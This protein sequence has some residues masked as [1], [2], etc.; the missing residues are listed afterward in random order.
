MRARL[1]YKA[2][3]EANDREAKDTFRFQFLKYCD[4]RRVTATLQH[5]GRADAAA[6]NRDPRELLQVPKVFTEVRNDGTLRDDVDKLSTLKIRDAVHACAEHAGDVQ[7]GAVLLHVLERVLR[8]Q[9]ADVHAI[10]RLHR[11]KLAQGPVL[12]AAVDSH[13]DQVTQVEK[14]NVFLRLFVVHGRGE[15]PHLCKSVKGLDERRFRREL[16]DLWWAWKVAHMRFGEERA[17]VLTHEFGPNRG[18]G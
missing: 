10:N 12:L 14:S 4:G 7:D 9:G 6:V 5:W 1:C 13:G 15:Y 16:D 8:R 17:H 2:V 11:K 18:G 3:V